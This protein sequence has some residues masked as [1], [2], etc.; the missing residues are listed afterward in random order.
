MGLSVIL[1]FGSG[2]PEVFGRDVTGFDG[3]AATDLAAARGAGCGPES[4][5]INECFAT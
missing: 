4:S 3:I 1:C 5:D 2:C